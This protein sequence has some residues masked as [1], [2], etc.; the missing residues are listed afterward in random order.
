MSRP[1]FE[2]TTRT[3]PTAP[4]RAMVSSMAALRSSSAVVAT[5]RHPSGSTESRSMISSAMSA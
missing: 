5:R 4:L 2:A 3:S 1:R